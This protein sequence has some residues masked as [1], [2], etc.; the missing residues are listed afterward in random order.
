MVLHPIFIFCTPRR[1]FDYPRGV[2]FN[3]HILNSGHVFDSPRSIASNFSALHSHTHFQRSRRRCI[4]F[5]CFAPS[6]MFFLSQR[7]L[8][9]VFIFYIVAIIFRDHEGVVSSFLILH[10][11]TH[12]CGPVASSFHILYS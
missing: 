7:L 1:I 6:D 3:F 12:F 8:R 5:L 2:A 11:R 10:S 9:S 4:H